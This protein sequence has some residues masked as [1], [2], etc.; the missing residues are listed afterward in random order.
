MN[1]NSAV[2]DRG[3][4]ASS[5][6]QIAIRRPADR[7]RSWQ[8]LCAIWLGLRVLTS[9]AIAIASASRPP[10]EH[11][12][13]IPLWPPSRPLQ[14]WLD[15]VLIAP[16]QQWDV[17]YYTSIVQN[18]YQ[19]DDGTA[20][21]HPLLPWLAAGLDAGI[22]YP[23]LALLLVSS[24]ASILLLLAFERLARL[25]L[26]PVQ[27]RTGTLLFICTPPAFILFAPYT[28]GLFLL[29]AVLC[30]LYARRG[31]WWLAGAAG[32]LATLTRQQGLFLALPLAWELWEAHG[33]RL[34]A[35]LSAWRSW[36][37]LLLIPAGYGAWIL[38]RAIALNDV[39]PDFTSP[40]AVIYS[41]LVSPSTR[42]VLPEQAYWPPWQALWYAL[43]HFGRTP[44]FRT[45]IDLFL[46]LGFMLLAVVAW[47]HMRISYRVY[48]VAIV[49]VSLSLHTGP[50]FPYMALPRHL[51][52]AFPVFI[53]LGKAADARSVR[54]LGVAAGLLGML[55]LLMLYETQVWIP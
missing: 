20:Q 3:S 17:A 5:A 6:G 40:Q 18:G 26:S 8:E 23:L 37:A 14:L 41:I 34:R 55:F 51:L 28:E 31:A 2:G 33:R 35:A 11:F 9:L 25:D 45:G 48:V 1:D 43:A 12:R 10:P 30:F 22:G 19:K 36:A 46:G 47:P 54:R 50:R 29:F 16:W 52:L 49:L 7:P 27:A 53:G 24:L 21:F 15:R 38:Y 13:G 42:Q 44:D 39:A 4:G 32:A